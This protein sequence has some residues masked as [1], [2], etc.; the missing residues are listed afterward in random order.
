MTGK[1]DFGRF[2]S[3]NGYASVGGRVRAERL[4]PERRREIARSGWLALV[5][6]RYDGDASAAGRGIARAANPADSI[7]YGHTF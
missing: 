1:D 7:Y 2:T 4:T 5:D 6:R 3:G